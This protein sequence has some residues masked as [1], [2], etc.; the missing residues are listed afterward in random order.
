MGFAFTLIS[1]SVQRHW[2]IATMAA[3]CAMM[4]SAAALV[5]SD[6]L[7][8][9]TD[10]DQFA[11]R[12]AAG[13][14][15]DLAPGSDSSNADDPQIDGASSPARAAANLGLRGD[16]RIVALSAQL[17]GAASQA[18]DALSASIAASRFGGGYVRGG[19]LTVFVGTE[20]ITSRDFAQ[21][22]R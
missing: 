8:F 16:R 4:L 1:T 14:A 7:A 20:Q 13:T 17:D 22:D 9:R 21:T 2:P 12:A 19:Q 3:A 6:S 11:R 18:D 10:V 15:T 5:A